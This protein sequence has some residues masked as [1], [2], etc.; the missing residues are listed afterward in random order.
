[1]NGPGAVFIDKDGTL[2]RDI[3]FNADPRRIELSEGAAEG[4]RILGRAGHPLFVVTNQPG[5]AIGRFTEADF[6]KVVAALH[7]I[8][9]RHGCVL[10][11]VYHCPHH[12]N[13]RVERYRSVCGCRK[14]LDGLLR[15]AA[16]DHGIDLEKSWMIGDILNDVEAGRRA[17]CRTVFIDNGNETEWVKSPLRQPDI[18]V[19][20]FDEAA[21]AVSLAMRSAS[22]AG[23]E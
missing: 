19:G 5:L 15:R 20:R 11:G 3:P 23:V 17:G 16:A 22:H 13:G 6:M 18:T 21:L 1:M 8:F 14:P 9:A 10:A 2:V 12:P 4:L 7:G